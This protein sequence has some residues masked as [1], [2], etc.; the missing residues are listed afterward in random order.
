LASCIPLARNF[1]LRGIVCDAVAFFDECVDRSR[2]PGLTFFED[3]TEF[4]ELFGRELRRRS[5]AEA[6]SKTVDTSFVPCVCPS[7]RRGSRDPDAI[8]SFLARVACVEVL[9]VAESPDETGLV[10][11]LGI[12]NR[13]IKLT[14]REVLHNRP[15]RSVF[16]DIERGSK[17]STLSQTT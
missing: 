17:C 14:S 11:L 1:R 6:Q 10:R 4:V 12:C 2:C 5:A 9:H 3:A 16:I 7:M 13:L 8:A 15:R